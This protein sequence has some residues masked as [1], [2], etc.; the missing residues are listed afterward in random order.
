MIPLPLD[1]IDCAALQRL[2]EQQRNEDHS[3]EYKER[4]AG[5]ADS[6]KVPWLLK[7][8]CSFANS[9]GGDLVLGLRSEQGSPA[10]LV[11]VDFGADSVDATLL[12]LDQ[13][14]RSS[15]EPAVMGVRI[16]AVA[17]SPRF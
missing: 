6:E 7:P 12:R 13:V 4:L 5:N 9:E 15:L 1:E 16:K 14:I 17:T 8:I 11:G 3:I 10:E 2:I